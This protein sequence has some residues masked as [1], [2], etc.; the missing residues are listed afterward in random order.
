MFKSKFPRHAKSLFSK[1]MIQIVWLS[2][3]RMHRAAV[4]KAVIPHR[5]NQINSVLHFS[6][7]FGAFFPVEI[8]ILY[9]YQTCLNFKHFISVF[10]LFRYISDTY[11]CSHAACKRSSILKFPTNS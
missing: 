5:E 2:K 11:S 8:Q 1:I 3:M 4:F 6:V 10:Q 7:K 9:G